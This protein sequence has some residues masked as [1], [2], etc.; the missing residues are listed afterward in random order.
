[1]NQTD[2]TFF[3]R[4]PHILVEVG[5]NLFSEKDNNYINNKEEIEQKQKTFIREMI[6]KVSNK[7]SADDRSILEPIMCLT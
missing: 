7:G 3:S 1:M 2:K 6:I 5:E 4:G